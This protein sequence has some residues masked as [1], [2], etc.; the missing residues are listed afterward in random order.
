MAALSFF[1]ALTIQ[2]L[3]FAGAQYNEVI[4]MPGNTL[5]NKSLSALPANL[6]ADKNIPDEFDW[7]KLNLVTRILNQNYPQYCG[8]SWAHSTM[9][10]FADRVKIARAAQG[11]SEGA[12]I[13][14][15]VQVLLNCG[16][17]VAGS[18]SG[19]SA[20][21]AHQ[22]IHRLMGIPYETCQLYE[23]KDTKECNAAGI[24]QRCSPSGC[25]NVR[26]GVNM[27]SSH[28]GF[29]TTSL[30]NATISEWG[31]VSGDVNI[32][33][34]ILT[35]GPVVC[36]T[37]T[38]L[39][40]GYR[41]G[42]LNGE[43]NHSNSHTVSVTGWGVE[44]KPDGTSI[45]YWRVR[46]SWGE[47]WGESGFF[48]VRRESNNSLLG[49][50]CDWAQPATWVQQSLKGEQRHRIVNYDGQR[51]HSYWAE[52]MTTAFVDDDAMASIMDGDSEV[53]VA[54]TEVFYKVLHGE[55]S[56]LIV[57]VFL[58]IALGLMMNIGPKSCIK[59]LFSHETWRGSLSE[60]EDDNLVTVATDCR[61][62]D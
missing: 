16:E 35:R 42:I 33:K 58:G 1:A 55:N 14:F 31:Q 21:G 52:L 4:D 8:S 13:N 32:Q 40:Q 34:E 43:L 3:A 15:A 53:F 41:G 37:T 17:G 25:E 30:P 11:I 45:P 56:S 44:T 59:M 5:K 51:V 20:S 47:F 24:C 26:E 2:F 57:A 18:C 6:I 12:E 23:A 7:Y 28:Y 61:Y 62:S 9:S 38:D 19:G 49:A 39:L 48:R 50:T 60:E 29:A 46:N 54:S 10:A 36:R 22:I 27:D